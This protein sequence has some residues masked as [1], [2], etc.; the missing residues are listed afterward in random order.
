MTVLS[1]SHRE[2]LCSFWHLQI[3]CEKVTCSWN[4]LLMLK[5]G[6]GNVILFTMIFTQK[7][8][9]K[10]LHFWRQL[11]LNWAGGSSRDK[12]MPVSLKL[13]GLH[14]PTQSPSEGRREGQGPHT[15][16]TCCPLL[17]VILALHHLLGEDPQARAEKDQ[18]PHFTDVETEG[19]CLQ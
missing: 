11:D 6:P 2:V 3:L 15:L 8:M 10:H 16:G 4:L 1:A 9:T 12:W 19:R 5:T 17:P 14:R 7:S 18:R 13:L